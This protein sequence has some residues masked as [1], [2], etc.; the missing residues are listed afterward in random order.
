MKLL[1]ILAVVATLSLSATR[2][3]ADI[4]ISGYLANPAGTDSPYEYVQLVALKDID[5]AINPYSVIFANNGTATSS[6]WAAGGGLTYQFSL[7]AGTVSQ[8]G[9]FYVGG[10]GKLINGAPS[11]VPSAS[12]A[13]AN[14]IREI[15]TATTGGDNSRGS[16]NSAGIVG[17]G[18]SNAD[19]I[20]VFSGTTPGAGTTPLDAVFYGTGVGS[21]NPGSGGYVLPNNDKYL[22]AQ[23]TF[24]NGTN[25][26]VFSD[27]GSGQ[28]TKLTGTYNVDTNS[29]DTART[30]TLLTPTALADINT[31]ITVFSAV[32][33]PSSMILAGALLGGVSLRMLRRR[34]AG[35]TAA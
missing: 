35:K 34:L 7:T 21:S 24:G 20:A 27:P 16:S 9:V 18:G 25:T 8:G 4:V 2:A 5:F 32:P 17:N 26:F 14:W 6:G 12:I 22:N 15:N 13:S 33:E 30:S 19:G 31:G 29:W 11:G 10:N 23:G 28:Y 1:K 3:Q